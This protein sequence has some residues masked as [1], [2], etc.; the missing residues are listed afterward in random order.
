MA[1]AGKI[2]VQNLGK[3]YKIGKMERYLTLRDTLTRFSL[4]FWREKQKA[5]NIEKTQ[6]WAIRNISFEVSPGEIVGIIGRNG[7]GKS[8]L[9]KILAKVTYPTEGWV[10]VYGRIGSILEVG[11]GFHPELTGRENIYLSGAIL[12]MKKKEIQRRFDEIVAFSEMEK[13]LDTPVKHYS[14]GMFVRLA[15]SVAAHLETD[16]LLVDEVLSIGDLSFQKKCLG[17][18]EGIQSSGRT[19]LFVSHQLNQIRRLCNRVFWLDSGEI[20]LQGPPH[21]VV[22]TY[23]KMSAGEK[24]YSAS[25]RGNSGQK[26]RFLSWR[27]VEPKGSDE[28][29]LENFEEVRVMFSLNVEQPVFNAHHGVALF[30]QENQLVWGW[31]ANNLKFSP[32]KYELSYSFNMLPLKPGFYSWRVSLY[33][34][35]GLVDVWDAFPDFLV[36]LENYQHP[37]DEWNGILNLPFK[38]EIENHDG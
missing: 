18:M 28:H 13:F 27:I 21:E 4:Q 33:D 9:L 7:A 29:R 34:D 3:K 30:N 25:E 6:I 19:I 24:R 2:E 35:E 10:K 38:F 1:K 11:T 12:G 20:R 14:S 8:T 22:A 16:I 23:E 15:F 32:G 36:A 37:R 5:Q 31:A 26:A 17:K